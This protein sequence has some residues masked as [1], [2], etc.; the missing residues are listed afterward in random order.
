MNSG[1]FFNVAAFVLLMLWPLPFHHFLFKICMNMVKG[2]FFYECSQLLEGCLII[3]SIE[4]RRRS[5]LIH[6]HILNLALRYHSIFLQIL[7]P[8]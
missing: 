4:T 2:R 7:K 1:A 3:R 6:R 8:C 5:V